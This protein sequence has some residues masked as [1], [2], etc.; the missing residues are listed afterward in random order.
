MRQEEAAEALG[1][2][3]T[4]IVSIEQG[5]RAV[6]PEEVVAFARLYGRQVAELERPEPSPEGL[7]VQFRLS[8]GSDPKELSLHESLVEFERLGD[9][10]LELERLLS[11]P[12][13][14]RE[15]P[16]FSLDGLPPED[17]AVE[18]ANRE[19]SR[20]AMGE[21][22][23]LQLRE[24][25]EN[26]VGLRIFG[27][28]LPATV[29]AVFGYTD[30]L[31]GCV[32]I[33]RKHPGGRQL[34]SLAHEYG[35]FLTN[36]RRPEV[37]VVGG[38]QR[39]RG[40]ERFVEAFARNFLMPQSGVVRTFNSMRQSRPAGATPADFLRLAQFFGVSMQAIV[41]RLEELR[42]IPAGSWDR[43]V[44]KQFSP[45]EGRRLLDM[46]PDLGDPR[47]LPIRYEQ[48]ATEAYVKGVIS[49]GQFAKFLRRDRIAARERAI[50]LARQFDI[51]EDGT[52]SELPFDVMQSQTA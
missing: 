23:A 13:Q 26:D 17:A 25:L 29:A 20:L 40:A 15:P 11:A 43:L 27:L 36:R 38:Y 48:L 4:T 24:I 5:T 18:L 32:G 52:V 2:A 16:P 47:M 10:Y 34:W 6:R 39:L 44:D 42:L 19:R 41:L 31:G 3:R 35:H 30:R 28:D 50:A 22:G 45:A 51:G 21:G 49:E 14:R 7:A 12:L 8:P 9:D 33:N 37:T 1:L 46:P